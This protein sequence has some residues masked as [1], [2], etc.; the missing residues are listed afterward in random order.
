MRL[1]FYG[2]VK[3][4]G[5]NKILLEDDDTK[6]FLDFGMSFNRHGKFFEE[7]LK[8]RVSC[9]MSD[10]VE[11]GLVPRIEGIYREDLLRLLDWDIQDEPSVDAVFLSHMHLDHTAYVSFLDKR[12]PI[13][14][15]EISKRIANVLLEAGQR[16]IDR[17][18]YN[19][20]PR[21]ILNRR[22]PP[23][24]RMF[25]TLE[26]GK[27]VKVGSL[28][29]KPFS[30]SHSIP[31]AISCI[32]YCPN[33]IVVYT[34]DLRLRGPGGD[35]TAK[36]VEEAGEEKPDVLLCE[37]TRIDSTDS[38]TEE[39]VKS[40][41]GKILSR[42][43]QLVVADYASRDVTRFKTFYDLAV[44]HGRK[45]VITKKD[46]YLIQ[47][48]EG[49][50]LEIP[51]INSEGILIYKER[52]KTGRYELS[53]YSKWERPF[54]DLPNTK[55]SEFVCKNQGE[56]ILH[57]GFF[58]INELIDIKPK[59][60]S[61]YIHSTSEPHNEEQRIDEE[62]LDNWLKHFDMYPRLQSHA[63]GHANRPDLVKIIGG[64]QP[65]KVTPIHTEHPELFNL[66]HENVEYPKLH[67][68]A[69]K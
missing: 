2:G 28:E 32:V 33:G 39:D 52:K 48:L 9:G 14:C 47:E 23:I 10:F 68:N 42:A 34:G 43:K 3:E 21:P 26:P 36:F 65:K 1:S 11:M 20:K 30:V 59:K 53:D 31:G 50:G 45:L 18:I 8:P 27:S 55:D 19:F 69:V 67:A 54:L 60:G 35:L 62:R 4:I 46:A 24:E 57:L 61:I 64:I 56:L 13:Y 38:R 22:E 5:G 6:V 51:D 41:S 37:G 58:N 16:Q 44:E 63:S 12:I 66:I 17:E 40:D 25:E 7:Y 29:I 15:S 49:T